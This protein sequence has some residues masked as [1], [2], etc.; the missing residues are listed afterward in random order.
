MTPSIRPCSLDNY[1]WRKDLHEHEEESP[2][3][4]TDGLFSIVEALDNGGTRAVLKWSLKWSPEITMEES[5]AWS[6]P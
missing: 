2:G 4:I 6:A 1:G 3:G 5:K